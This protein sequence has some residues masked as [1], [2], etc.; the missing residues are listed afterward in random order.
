MS[1]SSQ[2]I[3]PATVDTKTRCAMLGTAMADALGG[4][5]EF[6]K[7]FKYPHVESMGE[8]RNFGIKLPPGTWTDDTSMM[9]CLSRS[10]ARCE[11]FSEADQLAAYTRWLRDGELSAVGKCFD[12]GNTVRGAVQLYVGCKENGEQALRLIK[13]QLGGERNSGNGSLMRLIGVPLVFWR[14]EAEARSKARRSSIATHPNV[15]C[16]E[17][18]EVWALVVA[19]MMKAG[20]CGESMSKLDVLKIFAG[21]DYTTSQLK[22][23]LA[24]SAQ[25]VETEH[26]LLRLIARMDGQIP[27]VADLPSSGYVVHTLVAALYAFLST[28]NFEAGAIFTANLGDDADTVAAV[29]GGLAGV[30]Y[31][32]EGDPFWSERVQE[33]H[34]D[35]IRKDLLEHII[36]EVVALSKPK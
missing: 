5:A 31:G 21:F 27:S 6:H 32:C 10:M 26:P 19:R 1:L 17:A 23:L 18:C 15:L 7:R 30:W 2:I 20:T 24:C 16:Q 34:S 13:E 8:N 12:V 22:G 35:L 33:W 25:D 4:P 9:L 14:D 28:P 3:T 11:E 36:R 29:Y